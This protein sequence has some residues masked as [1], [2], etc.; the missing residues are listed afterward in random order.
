MASNI[1]QYQACLRTLRY[2]I[3][4]NN[5]LKQDVWIGRVTPYALVHAGL[6]NSREL[7][8]VA[9]QR[10]YDEW[11]AVGLL[12]RRLPQERRVWEHNTAYDMDQWRLVH[13]EQR[14]Y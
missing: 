8:S 12:E 7:A 11:E 3:R 6:Y 2:N 1:G 13:D 9:V 5:H 14:H 4:T 10:R